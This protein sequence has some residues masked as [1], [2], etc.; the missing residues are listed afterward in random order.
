MVSS[1]N[2][3][4][5]FRRGPDTLPALREL[6]IQDPRIVKVEA[7]PDGY[8]SLD[9]HDDKVPKEIDHAPSI[10]PATPA[11][12]LS[13][14]L[15]SLRSDG[16]ST[17]KPSVGRSAFHTIVPGFIVIAIVGAAFALFVYASDQ[18]KDIV[19]AW[20]LPQNW[21]SSVLRPNS[22]QGS[23]A[24]AKPVFKPLDQMLTQNTAVL[25]GSA[26]E[27]QY[28]LEAMASDLAAVRRLVDQ[29]AARQDQMARDIATLQGAEQNVSPKISPLPQ[30][31]TVHIPR[32]RVEKTM[33]KVPIPADPNRPRADP[34][35]D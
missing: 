32:K 21:V 9:R 29:L 17:D 4:Q 30:S 3:G 14:Q 19:T 25:P 13:P 20:G 5:R 16:N 2:P 8:S 22:S 34:P 31:P 28:Q 27:L 35:L 1:Q 23:D 6:L 24:A 7:R 12:S 10:A 15:A 26:P 11:T 18:K 33:Y